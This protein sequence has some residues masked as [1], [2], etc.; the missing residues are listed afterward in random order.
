ML[1]N[2]GSPLWEEWLLF[3]ECQQ[4]RKHQLHLNVELGLLDVREVW[5][6]YHIA[7]TKDERTVRAV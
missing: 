4:L 3:K 1:K 2:I 6:Y 7:E 5:F